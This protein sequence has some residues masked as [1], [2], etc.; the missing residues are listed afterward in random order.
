MSA[1]AALLRALVIGYAR[2]NVLR[3]LVTIVAVALGV[4]AA[5]AID[6]AN[7]TAIDSFSRSVD[8]IANHVNLQ[9]FGIGRGF[10]ERALL[11]VQSVDGVET[12]NPVVEGELVLGAR[13]GE[14][15]SGEIVRVLGIDLTRAS[16]PES[17]RDSQRTS[18]A[19]DLERYIN[20]GGIFVSERIARVYH[21]S[22]GRALHAYAGARPV[23]LPVMGVIPAKTAGVDSSVAFVDV[24]T[25]QEL[26]GSVGRLNRIDLVVDPPRLA[27]VRDR[28]ARVLPPDARVL[29]PRTR[30][31]EIR[32]MLASFSMNLTALADVALLVGMYL[33]Y[34][35]VAISV[36]QRKSEIGT[37]RAL[38]ARR[39]QIFVTFLLEGALFGA[40][41]AIAGIVL[42]LALARFSVAAVQTTVS[43]L[44]LGSHADAVVFSWFA[45]VKAVVLG[46]ALAMI[47]AVVPAVEAARTAPARAM[48]ASGGFERRIP[49]FSRWT[50]V[51]GIILLVAAALAARLPAYHGDIP[52]FGYVAGVL[53]IAGF[54]LLTPL[55]L[56]SVVRLLRRIP[57][58]SATLSAAFLG[59]SPRR[60]A[61]AIASLGVAVAMMIAI[62]I[63][64]GSFR[65][66][67]VAWTSDTL[68]SDLYIKA[69][70]TVDAS[71]RGNFPPDVV[72]RIARVPGVAAVDTYRGVTAPILGRFVEFGST[73]T[74]TLIARPMLRF[75]GNVD[76]AAL[77][78]AMRT[79]NIAVVSEPFHSH[80]NLG[81]GDT[82]TVPTPSGVERFRIGAVFNDYSTTGG[83]VMIDSARYRA[84]FGDDSVDSIAVTAAHGAD[85]A[86]VRSRIERALAPLRVDIS[87]NRELRAFALSIFDRTF[88]ITNALYLVSMVIAVLGVVSTLFA[89]VIERRSD[90]ALLRYVGL[91]RAGVRRMV[92][93]QAAI[94]GALAA[95]LGTLLGIALAADL[96]YVI[97]RQSF[98][99]LIEWHSPG[100]FY[101]EAALLVMISALVAALYPA[102]VAARIKTS[103]VLRVE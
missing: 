16:V 64:V 91:A 77:T 72:Q 27:A 7:G 12:A 43:T 4:A 54:S 26:F 61:V 84:L 52:L 38:G 89:L 94:V 30:L 56:A 48:R 13:R 93:A 85:L 3:A 50:A 96:V 74:T 80:F 51:A 88:A 79:S 22:E 5:Y 83:T 28:I 2:A 90:I 8:V 60:F 98:G 73:D 17:A 32:R 35:A 20:S 67:V 19:F 49:G 23:A 99:W 10:D 11:A 75:I 55:V 6:L 97:N 59:G 44:Y 47:S 101:V 15:E 1:Q 25:A 68:G 31:G 34:N 86:L 102:A 103:E 29:E 71:S 87:T 62:A 40:I 37:L 9:V 69:P 65:T 39:G 76:V 46:T 42:G 45:T 36:V 24:A 81:A 41:G 14:P 100:F 58:P 66:T 18:A 82:F 63:L 92:L 53:L 33:I 95:L 78:R 21:A 57:R 70:G